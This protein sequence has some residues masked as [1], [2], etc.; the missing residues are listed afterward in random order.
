MLSSLT[1]VVVGFLAACVTAGAI[2]VLFALSPSEALSK[3]S[4]SIVWALEAATHSAIF[5]SAFAL[6][7]L[8]AAEW[9]KIRSLLFYLLA[10]T[11]IALLGFTAQFSSEVAGQSTIL[12]SYALAAF[13][14]TGLFS[15]LIYWALAGRF[16]GSGRADDAMMV[17][18]TTA[19]AAPRIAVE[20][21]VVNVMDRPQPRYSALKDKLNQRFKR[22]LDEDLDDDSAVKSEKTVVTQPPSSASVPST[23]A[24]AAKI[25]IEKDK[26]IE[27]DQNF[28]GDDVSEFEAELKDGGKRN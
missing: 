21:S 17:L 11:A 5:S 10:G 3:F 2:K 24:P 15:G 6:I 22:A 9:L 25:R 1:R 23:K 26:D 13:L 27:D 7:A 14:T 18:E 12:N 20:D 16:A 28:D 8:G 19:G 4:Q